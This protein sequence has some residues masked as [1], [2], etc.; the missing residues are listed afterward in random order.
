MDSA[1]IIIDSVRV[2]LEDPNKRFFND[3]D[4]VI[5]YND[6][7][8]EISEISEINETYITVQRR[9]NAPY[10]DLRAFLPP[11]ALRVTAVWNIGT[12]KW[13]HPVTVDE[14]DNQ[15]GRLWENRPDKSRWWWM[16]GLFYLGTYPVVT[17]D[18]DPMQ[19]WFSALLPHVEQDG[20]LITGLTTSAPI[21]PDFGQMIENYMS[22]GRI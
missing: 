20:G 10:S 11:D 7:I 14:L 1:Q 17:T 18:N 22:F 16:R 19:V 6:A 9:K 21:P 13:M 3:E 2:R 15:V 5:S 12:N 8:D 4:M